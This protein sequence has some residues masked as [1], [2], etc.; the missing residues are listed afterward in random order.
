MMMSLFGVYHVLSPELYI[1]DV[2]F[3]IK[4]SGVRV[5]IVM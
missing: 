5:N 2:K 4:I 3:K 1:N